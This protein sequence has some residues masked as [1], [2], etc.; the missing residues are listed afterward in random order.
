M[1]RCD[2]CDYSDAYIFVKGDNTVEEANHRDRKNKF[3]AFKNNATFISSI[4]KINGV[5]IEN[6][7]DLDNVT[8]M[9]N[10]IEHSKHYRKTTGSLWNY[11]RD[12]PN[13][14]P[15]NNY[16]ANPITNS[17]SFKCK[18]SIIGKT[19]NNYSD[20]NTIIGNVEIVVPLKHLSYFWKTLDMPLINCEVPVTLT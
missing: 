7:E 17:E 16:N 9:Y 1:V 15:A 13:N 14:P 2:F 18:S 3:L 8:P 4:S 5:L 6:R 11:Y 10:L 12:E 20:N 19:P